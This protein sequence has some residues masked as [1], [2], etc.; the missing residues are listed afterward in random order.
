MLNKGVKSA[1]AEGEATADLL[2]TMTGGTDS[3]HHRVA[4]WR[5]RC[6]DQFRGRAMD[7]GV[8]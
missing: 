5:R 1:I 6:A 4:V 2:A 3:H 7:R 8:C